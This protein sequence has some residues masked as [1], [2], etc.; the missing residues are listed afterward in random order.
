LLI[1]TIVY[2]DFVGLEKQYSVMYQ[3]LT[4]ILTHN[5][6]VAAESQTTQPPTITSTSGVVWTRLGVYGGSVQTP[7]PCMIQEATLMKE[8]T[9]I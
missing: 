7:S 6:S 9:E 3:L 5:E 2:T 8:R 4:L 1:Q